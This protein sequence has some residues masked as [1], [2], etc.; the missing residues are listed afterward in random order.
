[1][2]DP[3]TT[4]PPVPFHP[5]RQLRD[6]PQIDL[7]WRR[8]PGRRG[9]VAADG[10]IILNPDQ[11]QSERRCALAHELAH[12]ELGHLGGCS[13]GEEHAARQLAARWLIDLPELLDALRWA[14]DL[15]TVAD[16]LWVDQDTLMARLD[17]LTDD[18]R[19]QIARLYAEVERGC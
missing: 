12:V 6:H 13:S 11:M 5:W 17:G 4:V 8:L 7:A 9:V 2:S 16:E 3:I 15:P 10:L 18:E 1:M 19:M 14:D